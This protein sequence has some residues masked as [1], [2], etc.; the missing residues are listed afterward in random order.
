MTGKD[1]RTSSSD[2]GAVPLQ[3]IFDQSVQ[4]VELGGV[5]MVVIVVDMEKKKKKIGKKTMEIRKEKASIKE[6]RK[7]VRAK[8][9]KVGE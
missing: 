3:P 2:V 8:E 6:K 5:A 9:E 4:L 1:W 7:V